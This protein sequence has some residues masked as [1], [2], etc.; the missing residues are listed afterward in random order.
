MSNPIPGPTGYPLIGVVP[1]LAKHGATYFKKAFEQYGDIVQFKLI[2]PGRMILVSHPDMVEHVLQRNNKNYLVL[3]PS[4]HM[5]SMM[6]N[7]LVVSNGEFW[8]RQRRM[9]HPIFHRAHLGEISEHNAAHITAMLAAWQHKSRVN[10]G[11]EMQRVILNSN[12]S[13]L[14]GTQLTDEQKEI[15]LE[16]VD[17]WLHAAGKG[18]FLEVP[19]FIPTVENIR[20]R[21]AL[22]RFKTIVR[23]MIAQRRQN[24]QPGATD[25][26]S[27]LVNAQDEDTH[28]GMTDQQVIDEVC[29]ILVPGYETAATAMIWIFHLLAQHPEVEDKVRQELD[30]RLGGRTPAAADIAALPYLHQ[31]ILECLRV[32]P[33]FWAYTRQAIQD[34]EIN[35]YRVPAGAIVVAS[36]YVTHKHPEFWPDAEVFA[37]ERFETEKAS[38]IHRGAYFPFGRGPRICIGEP[39][40]M[41]ILEMLTAMTLQRYALRLEDTEPVEIKTSMTVRPKREVWMRVEPLEKRKG[42]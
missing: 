28:E 32:H 42:G 11:R 30:A 34:D 12:L 20:L 6:G 37:P 3:R 25:L 15:T 39:Q 13:A 14:F 23:Q 33:P 4:L 19:P 1:L 38:T 18:M 8:L 9:I 40:G 21:R 36:P 31:V 24:P 10:I 29:S 26:L 17:R 16:S 22:R 41:L 2:G 5:K 35:G 7:G 27:L